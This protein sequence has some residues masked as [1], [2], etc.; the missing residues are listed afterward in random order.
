[1]I[2]YTWDVTNMF[3]RTVNGVANTVVKVHWYCTGVDE[4]NT[5][6]YKSITTLTSDPNNFTQYD[7]LTKDQVLSW[8]WTLESKEQIEKAVAVNIL[9]ESSPKPA[10]LISE[11]LPWN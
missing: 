7:Q 10:K 9:S 1:M 2:T 5:Y 8:I 11:P 6:T 3:C 4:D